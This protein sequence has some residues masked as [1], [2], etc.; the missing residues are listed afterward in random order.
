MG[1]FRTHSVEEADAF[2]ES[3]EGQLLHLCEAFDLVQIHLDYNWTVGHVEHT[4]TSNRRI[5]SGSRL[6][7]LHQARFGM[8]Y[9][10]TGQKKGGGTAA[11]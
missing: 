1:E 6:E 5:S 2:W 10:A 7:H 8:Q 11:E 9:S 4:S 3:G